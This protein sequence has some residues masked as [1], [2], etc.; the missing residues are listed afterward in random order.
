MARKRRKS[1]QV[2]LFPITN[3]HHLTPQSRQG[4]NEPS[5][6]LKLK[7]ERHF[8]WHQLFRKPNGKERT[9]EEVIALLLRVHKA[10]GRCTGKLARCLL[11]VRH[12]DRGEIRYSTKAELP[13]TGN[14][15]PGFLENEVLI[16]LLEGDELYIWG[17]CTEC[18]GTGSLTVSLIE[19]LTKCPTGH[20][21]M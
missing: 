13:A 21:V 15:C 14:G 19:L 18:E 7:A 3:Q 5:N 8:Y 2:T 4:N 10:K 20:A 11:V 6:L 17:K 1:T 9:L 12:G 16:Y